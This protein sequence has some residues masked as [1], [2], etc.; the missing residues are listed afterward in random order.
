MPRPGSPALFPCS[1]CPSSSRSQRTTLPGVELGRGRGP[2]G[3]VGGAVLTDLPPALRVCSSLWKHSTASP[4]PELYLPPSQRHSKAAYLRKRKRS[5]EREGRRP[6]SHSRPSRTP[7]QRP[8]PGPGSQPLSV[9][10]CLPLDLCA[11]VSVYFSLHFSTPLRV[12]TDL[13]LILWLPTSF[14]LSLS[15]FTHLCFFLF[16][17]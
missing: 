4:L 16:F 17:F 14:Y 5:P 1:P 11:C 2:D 15:L 6:G 10:S 9:P 8:L 7:L 12:S 13:A 3:R